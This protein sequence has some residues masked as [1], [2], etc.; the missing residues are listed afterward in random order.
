MS[1]YKTKF[2]RD[3]SITYWSV[4]CQVWVRHAWDIPDEELAAMS[5]PDREKS[6]RILDV[7]ESMEMAELED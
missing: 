1:N 4:Y 2:H 5:Q 7:A 3:G 6:I